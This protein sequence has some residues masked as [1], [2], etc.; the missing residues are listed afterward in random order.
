MVILKL[1][2]RKKMNRRERHTRKK[3][4]LKKDSDKPPTEV[5]SQH[6]I[7]QLL[8]AINGDPLERKI[9]DIIKQDL[10]SSLQ[11]PLI[12]DDEKYQIYDDNK[13][14][15]L[16]INNISSNVNVRDYVGKMITKYL[17]DTLTE[18]RRRFENRKI[19]GPIRKVKQI[20]EEDDDG[21]DFP[22][23]PF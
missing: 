3:K 20:E 14:L 11:E 16:T 5:L 8:G 22:D 15:V 1:L 10:L 19:M 21:L 12:Y 6:E 2:K 9:D 18:Q 23:I 17:N 7:D 13:K 4:I